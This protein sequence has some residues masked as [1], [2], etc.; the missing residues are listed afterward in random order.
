M[1]RAVRAS[2]AFAVTVASH[3]ATSVLKTAAVVK[4]EISRR[5]AAAELSVEL[6]EGQ[7]VVARVGSKVGSATVTGIRPGSNQPIIDHSGA[8]VDCGF[9]DVQCRRVEE[10]RA[11][12]STSAHYEA[13]AA[14]AKL[15]HRCLVC[16]VV[17]TSG[18]DFKLHKIGKKHRAR[19]IKYGDLRGHC[20][21]YDCV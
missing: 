11:H 8:L 21:W 7:A 18:Y 6:S 4:E 9:C 20:Q 14:T 19:L 3:A 2:P 10:I 5:R 16:S 12:N 17:V 1:V 15:A 13:A